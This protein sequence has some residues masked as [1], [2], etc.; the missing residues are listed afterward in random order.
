VHDLTALDVTAAPETPSLTVA[1]LARRTGLPVRTIRYYQT[2]GL[3]PAPAREGRHARYDE[4]H[5]ERLHLISEL[6]ARG[7][8]LDAVAE[9]LRQ[10][11]AGETSVS[12]W[13]GLGESLARPWVDDGPALLTEAE[14]DERLGDRPGGT[15]AALERAGYLERRTDTIPATFL[16][17]SPALLDLALEFEDAGLDIDTSGAAKALLELRLARAADE[18]VAHVTERVTLERLAR[19]GPAD[20][21]RFVDQLRPLA[22]RAADVLFAHQ[23][24][25]ALQQVLEPNRRKQ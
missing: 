22:R 16:V 24:E 13:L 1:E 2:K 14:M 18:L 7:L 5:V 15:A 9:V 20:V 17:P 4:G 3:L 8:R 23:M 19:G 10:H 11:G 25:R 6:H 12:E 21:A